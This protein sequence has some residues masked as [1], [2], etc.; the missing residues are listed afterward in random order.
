MTLKD[1]SPSDFEPHKLEKE[2]IKNPYLVFYKLFDFAH[3]PQIR[4]ILWNWLRI[5]VA[6]GYNKDICHFRERHRILYFYEFLEKVIEASHILY[7]ERKE[8][9]RRVNSN[10]FD[11]LQKEDFL[12]INLKGSKELYQLCRKIVELVYP[13]MIFLLGTVAKEKSKQY[14]LLI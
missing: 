1:Y 5:T 11:I 2:E 3:L 14:F 6:G 12:K 7:Q 8:E 4:T 9:L 13:V 10:Q